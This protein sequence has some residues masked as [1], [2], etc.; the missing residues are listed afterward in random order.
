MS[1][2][3]SSRLHFFDERYGH[4]TRYGC[5]TEFWPISQSAKRLS[6]NTTPRR[7]VYENVL[8][9]GYYISKLQG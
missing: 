3:M 8:L 9:A 2:E 6:W 1:L 7:L 5:L 4:V